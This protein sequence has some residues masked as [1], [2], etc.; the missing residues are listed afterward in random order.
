[1]PCK[2]KIGQIVRLNPSQDAKFKIISVDGEN[3]CKYKLEK[4]DGGKEKSEWISED[5]ITAVD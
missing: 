1:M 5:H 2:F 3:R 4:L